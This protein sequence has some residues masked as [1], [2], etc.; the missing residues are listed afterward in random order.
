MRSDIALSYRNHLFI[1]FLVDE[2]RFLLFLWAF[3]L[4]FLNIEVVFY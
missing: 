4:I 1:L 3:G 2:I